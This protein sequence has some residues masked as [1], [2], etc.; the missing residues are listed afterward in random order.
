MT[1]VGSVSSATRRLEDDVGEALIALGLYTA[2][3]DAMTFAFRHKM[4]TYID[5]HA[6]P[7]RPEFDEACE[8]AGLGRRSLDHPCWV[9][10]AGCPRDPL[11]IV[12]LGRPH[13]PTEVS[14]DSLRRTA[15]VPDSVPLLRFLERSTHESVDLCGRSTARPMD[16]G[17]THPRSQH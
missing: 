15:A 17:R 11:T 8:T 14:V 7:W 13:S 4:V 2:C 9:A 5:L 6:A 1:D 12:V 3:F 16:A 10:D